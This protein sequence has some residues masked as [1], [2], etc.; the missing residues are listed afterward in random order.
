MKKVYILLF[1]VT[2][3]LSLGLVYR[4]YIN[5]H[6]VPSTERKEKRVRLGYITTMADGIDVGAVN[7]WNRT[8]SRRI[9]N[10]EMYNG[11]EVMIDKIKNDYYYVIANDG[12]LRK[13]WCMK[14]FVIEK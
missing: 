8:D 9:K 10:C 3:V 12:S 11:E 13:G 7:L 2:V 5:P 4:K 14:G 1:V 6:E